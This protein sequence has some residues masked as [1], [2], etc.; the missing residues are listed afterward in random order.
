MPNQ[1]LKT[2]NGSQNAFAEQ[3][4][5]LPRK[6]HRST[7]LALLALLLLCLLAFQCSHRT[8]RTTPVSPAG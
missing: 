8:R 2:P 4:R 3:P 6:R 1:E 7:P 5:T